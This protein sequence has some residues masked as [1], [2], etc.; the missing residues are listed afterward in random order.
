M[1]VLDASLPG[2]DGADLVKHLRQRVLPC[3]TP[4]IVLGDDHAP[5]ERARF[6]WAGASAYHAKPLNVAEVDDSVATLLEITA[7]G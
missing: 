6:V 7:L 5:S 2:V 1:V 4:I 3:G